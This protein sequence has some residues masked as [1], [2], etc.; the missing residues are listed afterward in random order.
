MTTAQDIGK[1]LSLTH[2]PPLP[3]RKYSWY[4]FLLEAESTPGPQS[5][6]RDYVNE[7]FQW[8]HLTVHRIKNKKKNPQTQRYH[9]APLPRTGWKER[10]HVIQEKW[11]TFQKYK[12]YSQKLICQYGAYVTKYKRKDNLVP[13][14]AGIWQQMIMFVNNKTNVYVY[15][16]T[17]KYICIY[18]ITNQEYQTIAKTALAMCLYTNSVASYTSF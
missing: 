2:R 17:W 12:L 9:T 1:V 11:Y 16:G 15:V 13:L 3:P 6:R 14:S 7:K 18:T 10:V 4:S 8:H 5:D